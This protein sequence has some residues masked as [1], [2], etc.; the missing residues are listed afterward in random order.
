MSFRSERVKKRLRQDYFLKV[1]S[2]EGVVRSPMEIVHVRKLPETTLKIERSFS[3]LKKVVR[4]KR[5]FRDD[6]VDRIFM[7]YYNKYS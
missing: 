7:F 5:N 1:L 2:N 6:N 3:M 4:D